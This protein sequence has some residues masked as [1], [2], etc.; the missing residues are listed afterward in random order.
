MYTGI[1]N[2]PTRSYTRVHVP[3][4]K[5]LKLHALYTSNICTV[6]GINRIIELVR[7]KKLGP[8]ISQFGWPTANAYFFALVAP[9][10]YCVG[11]D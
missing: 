1:K 6:P 4:G 5:Y 3:W 2:R 8:I 7:L 10:Y 11:Y 9:Y